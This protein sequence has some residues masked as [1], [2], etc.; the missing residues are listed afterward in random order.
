MNLSHTRVFAIYKISMHVFL[1]GN[2]FAG[3]RCYINSA[4][5]LKRA[6]TSDIVLHRPQRAASICKIKK[7]TR[8]ICKKYNHIFFHKN[9]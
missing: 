2:H 4:D 5:T 6:D 7:S 9:G 8:N 1:H 3:Y